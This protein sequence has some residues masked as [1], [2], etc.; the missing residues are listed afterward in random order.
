MRMISKNFCFPSSPTQ[1]RIQDFEIREVLRGAL[2]GD[3]PEALFERHPRDALV[4]RATPGD[5]LPLPLTAAAHPNAN[6]DESPL[7]LEAERAR[8]VEPGRVLEPGDGVLE[9][10][11]EQAF[12]PERR[13]FLAQGLAER[14]GHVTIRGSA[15]G[16]RRGDPGADYKAR[17]DRVAR[18]GPSVPLPRETRIGG[19]QDLRGGVALRRH[20]ADQMAR[21]LGA[22]VGPSGAAPRS[23]SRREL[24]RPGPPHR[25]SDRIGRR[26]P[27]RRA[28]PRGSSSRDVRGPGSATVP[29]TPCVR[30]CSRSCPGNRRGI[31][32]TARGR[33]RGPAA[34]HRCLRP[35]VPRFMERSRLFER[36]RASSDT[37]PR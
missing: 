16:K 2:F 36:A 31:P 9:T 37:P 3:S 27:S 25:S 13:P 19:G 17:G 5:D 7:R 32:R 1:Y 4:L 34:N 35:W 28:A 15:H 33:C 10:P 24:P 29:S 8:P 11:G 23:G 14:A 18:R 22:R 21:D 20:G 12:V 6:E 26:A 30:R